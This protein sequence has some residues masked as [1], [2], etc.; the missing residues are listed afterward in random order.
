MQLA[1]P[2]AIAHVARAAVQPPAR[3]PPGGARPAPRFGVA[4]L[5]LLLLLAASQ[6]A[7]AAGAAEPP[8]AQAQGDVGAKYATLQD[9]CKA[10]GKAECTADVASKC[11]APSVEAC[12]KARTTACLDAAPQGATYV[13]DSAE[14]C[15]AAVTS[16]YATTKLTTASLASIATLCGPKLFS[17]PGVARTPCSVD[18]DCATVSGLRCMTT[19]SATGE[20]VGKCLK[21]NP[22]AASA[23]C[24]GEA[25]V[26][27]T[28]FFCELKSKTCA[29]AAIVTEG[30]QPGVIP[31]ASGLYCP[32]GGP[33][34]GG[35]K[36]KAHAGE[37]CKVSSDCGDGL[38]D[39]L[40][41]SA[42]GN[43]TGTIEL[44]KLDEMCVGFK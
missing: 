16:A 32:G 38:C 7:C 40:S 11:G 33:F 3:L 5:P 20:S 41:G 25:D 30:C 21:P 15:L 37:S 9:F 13:V 14:P 28:D 6:L 4:L 19:T 1:S 29:P 22:V 2:P 10:R 39:K 42:S 17:G 8:Q 23:P 24:G 35:C 34:G 12:I 26:C 44:N 27:P 43:C 36:E 31:C 18:Y